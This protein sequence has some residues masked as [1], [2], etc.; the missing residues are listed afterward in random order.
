MLE[1]I[2][3]PTIK[4][5]LSEEFGITIQILCFDLNIDE[6]ELEVMTPELSK[7]LGKYLGISDTYFLG[8]YQKMKKE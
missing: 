1:R 3:L 6:A 4:E 8:V 2:P 7:K 5:I